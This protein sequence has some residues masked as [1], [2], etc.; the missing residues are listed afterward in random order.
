M[1]RTN[2]HH[3]CRTELQEPIRGTN[4]QER[5][6]GLSEAILC[7]SSRY[8]PQADRRVLK[9]GVFSGDYRS[10]H[11]AVLEAYNA[12][13]EARSQGKGAEREFCRSRFVSRTTMQ[14]LSN[15]RVTIVPPSSLFEPSN[16]LPNLLLCI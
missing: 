11:L 9:L 1:P 5:A 13:E 4:R 10:D 14:M 15:L 8:P 16:S 3:R 7:R 2:L 12:W 6:G